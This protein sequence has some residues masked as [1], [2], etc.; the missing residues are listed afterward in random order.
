LKN[1]I[2]ALLA[3]AKG[4][5]QVAVFEETTVSSL[6]DRARHDVWSANDERFDSVPI[7]EL[8]ESYRSQWCLPPQ[9][10]S[11]A[12]PNLIAAA[13]SRFCP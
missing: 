6:D 10:R 9:E 8:R 12:L 3:A 13:R 4:V 5:L 11:D 2:P 7:Q 1:D